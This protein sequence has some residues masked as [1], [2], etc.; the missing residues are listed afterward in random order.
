MKLAIE[1]ENAGLGLLILDVEGEWINIIPQL[2]GKTVYYEIERNLKINPFD[3][4]DVGLVKLL[5]KETIFKGI[6]VEYRD[7]SPQMNYVLSK[8]IENSVS[9]PEL[10]ENVIHYQGEK[11]A[12]QARQ[13]GQDQDSA[14]R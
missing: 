7:L 5:L 1:A 11:L 2:H 14:P 9:I 12:V 3:P 6:E 8:C 4:N 10:I 13:L